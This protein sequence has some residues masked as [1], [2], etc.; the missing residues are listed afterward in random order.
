MHNLIE[1]LKIYYEDEWKK[2]NLINTSIKL[3]ITL[4]LNSKNYQLIRKFEQ[5]LNN[6]DMVSNFYI[7]YFTSD[8]TIYKII[9]NSSPDKFASEFE[10]DNF[11][12][13]TSYKIW[14]IE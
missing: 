8:M 10:L 2:I 12:I 4:S 5:K 9:Y 6:L 3:P 1:K 7:D 13:N 14:R 11:T